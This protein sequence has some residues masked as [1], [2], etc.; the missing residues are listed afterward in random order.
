MHSKSIARNH[1]SEA[2]K[3]GRYGDNILV[4]MNKDEAYVL[5][6]AAG[7]EK[8]PINPDT[9]LPEAFIIGISDGIIS[10][11]YEPTL[12]KMMATSLVAMVLVFKP[13]GLFGEV[14]A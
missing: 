11:F 4:H 9:G 7:V 12:A 6:K 13:T 5:A 8:L 2:A 10:V 3:K 14:R 1:L